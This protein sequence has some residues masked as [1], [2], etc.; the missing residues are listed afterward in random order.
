MQE[1]AHSIWK[2]CA[3]R[4]LL[5]AAQTYLSQLAML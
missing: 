2:F 1:G 4:K 3:F 5:G